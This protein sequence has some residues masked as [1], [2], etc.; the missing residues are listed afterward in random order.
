MR[1]I[2]HLDLDAFFI[3][4]ERI[5]DP[6]LEGR[7]VIVGGDPHGRGVVAACSYEARRYGLHS[8]M[9]IRQAFKLC[10]SGVYLHGHYDEYVHYSRAVRRILSSYAP[11]IEQASIDEF[12]MD[13]TGTQKIYGPGTS[14]ASMLQK[15]IMSELS[16]PCS[17]GI[18]GNKTVAKVASDC[19]KPRGITYV[20]PGMEKEF[21]APMPVEVLPGVG[22]VTLRQLNS[23]GFYKVGDVAKASAEYFSLSM[24]LCGT[25]IWEK[26][27]GRGHEYLNP[28]TEQKSIS[29]EHTFETDVVDIK[30]IE[31][32]L[33]R[34]TAK[35]AQM[36][37]DKQWQTSGITIKLR[38]SDFTTLNRSK[39]VEPTDDDKTIYE[40]ARD[41]LHKAFTRRVGI[42]LIGIHLSRFSPYCEQQLLFEE[43]EESR[44][45]NMLRAVNSLRGKYGFSSVSLGSV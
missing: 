31:E 26:A 25:D 21:L 27:Q 20:M 35:V 17:I 12:Y 38:Y 32:Y 30:V 44:R 3:S 36:M 42:R 15:K 41:L 1:T 40:V 14:L 45:R 22:R 28:P 6:R 5:L 16:L 11:A 24:G 4:V 2:F 37:R 19:M 43:A 23:K 34:L 29:K 9:P 7:P 8:A 10:P 13:F 39:S 33:F 18:A